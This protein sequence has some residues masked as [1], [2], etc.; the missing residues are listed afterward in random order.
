MNYLAHI[1]LSG[2][3]T[4]LMLGNFMADSIKGKD[5][6]KYH[7]DIQ[8][9]ILLHREIDTFTD[10]HP[11]VME[12]KAK[13]Y[14]VLHHYSG[15]AV[16]VLYDHVL[17]KNWQRYNAEKLEDYVS[18]IYETLT[19][20]KVFL[21][22]N[23]LNFLPIMIEYN[24]LVSY[25]NVDS[26]D[27]ILKQMNRRIKHRVDLSAAVP[28]MVDQQAEFDREFEIFFEDIRQHVKDYMADHNF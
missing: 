4:K 3:D 1:Y 7:D 25:R 24:W 8:R 22:K 16:D 14:S 18:N 10:S 11:I 26:I 21:T 6:L 15:V 5:Y 2:D 19:N 23:V 9:G 28:I 20:H 13:F 17:A 27:Q 12:S